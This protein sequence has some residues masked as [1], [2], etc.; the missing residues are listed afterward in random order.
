METLT[1]AARQ[2]LQRLFGLSERG[3]GLLRATLQCGQSSSAVRIINGSDNVHVFC[4]ACRKSAGEC[5]ACADGVDWL[6][7]IGGHLAK[8]GAANID[9][10]PGAPGDDQLANAA[11]GELFAPPRQIVGDGF[12]SQ[13]K[14]GLGFDGV[15]DEGI[16][17][18][19]APWE[20]LAPWRRVEHNRHVG[21]VGNADGFNDRV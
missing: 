6:Y 16:N 21:A 12:E 18:V 9:G 1:I 15:D 17:V 2:F 8:A 14:N 3:D 10:G 7:S 4:A 19:L 13:A 11:V 20:T 5:I